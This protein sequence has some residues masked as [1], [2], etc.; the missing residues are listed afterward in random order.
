MYDKAAILFGKKKRKKSQLKGSYS[1]LRTS[2][3]GSAVDL[4]FNKSIDDSKE[5]FQLIK[6]GRYRE[7]DW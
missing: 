3:S 5:E 6:R 7:T 4:D 2:A 1:T